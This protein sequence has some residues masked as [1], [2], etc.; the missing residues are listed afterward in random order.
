LNEK[1]D[2]EKRD[3]RHEQIV[4]AMQTFA[5]RLG[6]LEARPEE[7]GAAIMGLF[8][9]VVPLFYTQA[10]AHVLVDRAYEFARVEADSLVGVRVDFDG[11]IQPGPLISEEENVEFWRDALARAYER[12]MHPSHLLS[13][14]MSILA[15][16]VSSGTLPDDLVT[17]V[18]EGTFETAV[19]L[20]ENGVPTDLEA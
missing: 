7:R 17:T 9:Q 4:D 8:Q 6:E 2:D 20:R 18:V 11:L 15:T 5:S 13:G 14:S 1:H 12:G 16:L 19:N 10:D 3:A